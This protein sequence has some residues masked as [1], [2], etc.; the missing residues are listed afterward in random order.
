MGK[1]RDKKCWQ[2]SRAVTRH[3]DA[4]TIA[5]REIQCVKWRTH[6]ED[7]I[8]FSENS[9]K[10]I[11][12]RIRPG[13]P[14][15][16]NRYR[17][18][19]VCLQFHNFSYSFQ[20]TLCPIVRCDVLSCHLCRCYGSVYEAISS[21]V[22]FVHFL[23]TYLA[24]RVSY[25]FCIQMSF[26]SKVISTI[27]FRSGRFWIGNVKSRLKWSVT[28][29]ESIISQCTCVYL[30]MRICFKYIAPWSTTPFLSSK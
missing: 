4:G 1:L 9:K 5:D 14:L 17:K 23:D 12:S 24:G 30:M 27:S 2:C 13:S 3:A 19:D 22:K 29:I 10:R 8:E 21:V 6:W 11:I 20:Q 18:Y 26:D 15:W 16:R 7:T 28:Y 25:T